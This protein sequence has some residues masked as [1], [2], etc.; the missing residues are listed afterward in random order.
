MYI[1]VI[2]KKIPVPSR[3]F[4]PDSDSV[5]FRVDSMEKVSPPTQNNK[6][7][8]IVILIDFYFL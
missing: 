2:T 7:F 8:L 6:V 1:R 5:F 3:I 4:W